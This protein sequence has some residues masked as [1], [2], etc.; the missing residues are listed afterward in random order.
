MPELLAMSHFGVFG[1]A[2]ETESVFSWFF[3]VFYPKFFLSDTC[4][5]AR[6]VKLK[7]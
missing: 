6:R 3:V 2:I 5:A 4:T 1:K 7:S